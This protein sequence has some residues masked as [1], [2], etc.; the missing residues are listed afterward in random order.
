MV[1]KPGHVKVDPEYFCSYV[2]SVIV[3]VHGPELFLSAECGADLIPVGSGIRDLLFTELLIYQ[4]EIILILFWRSP[5]NGSS[6]DSRFPVPG[7]WP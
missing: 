3:L 7:L 2:A 5:E 6:T 4:L 1:D